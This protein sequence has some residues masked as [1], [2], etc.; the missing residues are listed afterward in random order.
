VPENTIAQ[1]VGQE[2]GETEILGRYTKD[3]L[4]HQKECLEQM[5]L[6]IPGGA[7]FNVDDGLFY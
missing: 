2:R 6:P 5:K 3:I 1:I 7:R 4:M